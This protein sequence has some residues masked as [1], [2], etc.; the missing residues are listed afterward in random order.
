MPCRGSW[1]T[2]SKGRRGRV[3][4]PCDSHFSALLLLSNVSLC[5]FSLDFDFP[6]LLI[7]RL[8]FHPYY[9][10]LCFLPH[11]DTGA[12]HVTKPYLYPFID[13][14]SFYWSELR[15]GSSTSSLL[16]N[17]DRGWTRGPPIIG[18]QCAFPSLLRLICRIS[19]SFWPATFV[20]AS[21]QAPPNGQCWELSCR[22]HARPLR[23]VGNPRLKA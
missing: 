13:T 19:T 23:D 21:G 8:S 10:V 20:V 16:V 15:A 3:S 18:D 5:F 2:A 4:R 9:F 14:T 17:I 1:L 12:S 22:M 7:S 6:F 11:S